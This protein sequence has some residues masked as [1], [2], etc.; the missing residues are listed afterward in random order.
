[1]VLVHGERDFAENDDVKRGPGGLRLWI[2]L[3][4]CLEPSWI[5]GIMKKAKQG[6]TT[7][8]ERNNQQ[9]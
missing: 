1:V 5:W 7:R 4:F 2:E 9:L 8:P 6:L 3:T